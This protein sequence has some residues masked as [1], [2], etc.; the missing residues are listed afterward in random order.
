MT[1]NELAKM[2]G[3]EAEAA[4]PYIILSSAPPME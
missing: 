4:R 3:A 2:I 1:V